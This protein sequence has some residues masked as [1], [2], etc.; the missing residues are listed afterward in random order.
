MGN[1]PKSHLSDIVAH[2]CQSSA[3]MANWGERQR[4]RG[5]EDGSTFAQSAQMLRQ[6]LRKRMES[7]LATSWWLWSWVEAGQV[8]G[9][10][11]LDQDAAAMMIMATI[12]VMVMVAVP[13]RMRHQCRSALV[14]QLA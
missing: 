2:Y 1:P 5:F 10:R 8:P 11:D 13:V 4:W 7:R 3:Q 14:A 12:V 9:L 6:A